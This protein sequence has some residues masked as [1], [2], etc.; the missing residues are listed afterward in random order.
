MPRKRGDKI[1][2]SSLEASQLIFMD[3]ESEGEDIHLAEDLDLEDT[4]LD[5]DFE[6]DEQ[7]ADSDKPKVV[8]L[9]INKH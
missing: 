9:L 2:Y 3:S 4:D 6:P 1:T 8:H 5:S 7:D